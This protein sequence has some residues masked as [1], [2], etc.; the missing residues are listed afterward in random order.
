MQNGLIKA[1]Q[2]YVDRGVPARSVPI[3]WDGQRY[4]IKISLTCQRNIWHKV[5][6]IFACITRIELLRST[7]S[8]SGQQGL[9]EEAAR[10]ERV[11]QHGVLVPE[12]IARQPGWLLL[13]DIG[14]CVFDEV[15]K[16]DD[17]EPLLIGA[18]ESLAVLHQKGGWHGTGQLRDMVLSPD[19]QVGFID[20]EEGVGEAMQR[21]AAQARD[22]LRF[23]VSVVRFD[24]GSGQLLT[25]LLEAYR[26]QAP[27][28]VWPHIRHVMRFIGV[29]AVILNPFRKK[30]G[31]DVRESLLVYNALKPIVRQP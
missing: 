26:A 28:T 1:V 19:G 24:D 18:I 10:L 4:W 11:A 8:A 6:D 30:L 9:D 27:K 31:R 14:P 22:V 20:F 16:R 7:V 23:L 17:K 13:S 15:Q 25:R 29:L 21:E 5:Q 2:D 12:V 3:D